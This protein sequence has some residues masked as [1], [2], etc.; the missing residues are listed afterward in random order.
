MTV[1]TQGFLEAVSVDPERHTLAIDGWAITH[2][3]PV[4]EFRLEVGSQEYLRAV[5]GLLPTAVFQSL[6]SWL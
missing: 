2:S 6:R 1:D 3:G 5:Y 4:R